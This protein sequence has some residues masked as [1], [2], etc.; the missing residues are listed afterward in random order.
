MAKA[1]MM[2]AKGGR[3]ACMLGQGCKRPPFHA[4]HATHLPAVPHLPRVRR[5]SGSAPPCFRPR[6]SPACV[7]ECAC[8]CRTAAC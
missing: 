5:Q 7:R 4:L 2:V 8:A 1:G 3:P 6:S